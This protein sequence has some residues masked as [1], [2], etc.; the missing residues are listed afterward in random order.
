MRRTADEFNQFRRKLNEK[1]PVILALIYEHATNLGELSRLI[2]N[3]HQVLAYAYQED[4]SGRLMINIYDP[5]LPGRDDV[6]IL[7]TP[8]VVGEESSPTGLQ[9][10]M[11]LK[12]TQLVGATHYR[13]VR[14]FFAMPY[15]YVK[16]PKSG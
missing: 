7:S 6:V 8:E 1:N 4:A 12:S 11:C 5:N 15:T 14:G 13:D 9:T 10:I 2:F 3:N 16:P